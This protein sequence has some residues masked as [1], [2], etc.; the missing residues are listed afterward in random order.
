MF[1]TDY[2][3]VHKAVPIKDVPRVKIVPRGN[4][5]LLD[6]LGKAITE[7]GE[8]LDKLPVVGSAG[9]GRLYSDYGRRR[10]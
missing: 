5:A 9:Q 3:F 4:T 10:E 2:E 8:R 7:T 1:D 6:A